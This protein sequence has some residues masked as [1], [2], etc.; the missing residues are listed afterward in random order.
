MQ[1]NTQMDRTEFRRKVLGA[2]G[3]G[4]SVQDELLSYNESAFDNDSI[5]FPLELPLPDEPF[6]P[7]WERY[8]AEAEQGRIFEYLRGRLVQLKLPIRAGISS[9]ETYRKIT[10][11]GIWDD[12]ARIEKGITL[13]RPESLR[14][15]LHSGP[16]G[17][18]G[19][20]VPSGRED[21]VRLIQALSAKN[22]PE[23]VP[24][25]MGAAIVS[26]YNNW[27]RL[28]AI[29]ERWESEHSNDFLGLEWAEEF[30]RVI[31]RKELYQDRFIIISDGPYSNVSAED[32]SLSDD[33]WR[34]MSL[35]IRTEHEFTHYF[36]L[37]LFG[38]MRN[39]LLDEVLADFMGITTAAGSFH[40]EWF[41]RYVGLEAFPRYRKGGRLE[42]YRGNPP[43]S[44]KAF[45]VLQSMTVSL[46]L[47]LEHFERS[48]RREMA[49]IHGRAM[50]LT[51]LTCL[52]VEELA[53][54]EAPALLDNA[55]RRAKAL[56]SKETEMR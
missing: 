32:L 33:E 13:D 16:A 37:R 56:L 36:T 35:L 5:D 41:L 27:D 31:A 26:G 2:F 29:R 40:S 21:F 1:G 17:R 54:E 12:E 38:S 44:E 20:L 53:S 24:D 49:S 19:V 14:L 9:S 52:T 15:F 42:N 46:A 45:T 30:N 10:L 39:R 55:V 43:L 28:N 7:A 23:R 47:N 22:E 11:K 3:A 50:I 8:C 48:H 51:A 18:I 25:S 6:V 4:N 34:R